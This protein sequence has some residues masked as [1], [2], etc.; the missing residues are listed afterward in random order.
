MMPINNYLGVLVVI[1][2][3]KD[4]LFQHNSEILTKAREI[5]DDLNEKLFAVVIGKQTDK[6]VEFCLEYG[7]DIVYNFE[8]NNQEW[9]GTDVYLNTISEVIEI[10]K[11]EIILL[12]ST[13]IGK[14]IASRL[15]VRFKTGVTA[16]CTNLTLEKDSR[17]LIQVRPAFGG[18]CLA[19]IE[20]PN[21]RPQI[22]TVKEKSFVAKKSFRQGT[23][24]NAEIHITNNQFKQQLLSLVNHQNVNGDC[25]SE[26]RVIVAG[27]LG[28]GKK[29]N[30]KLLHNLA[31]LLGG[32]VA[33]SRAIVDIGWISPEYQIGQTGKSIAPT[34]YIACGISG[35]IQHAIG[36]LQTELI[37]AINKD[38][39]APIFDYAHFGLVG[40]FEQVVT[41]L[42]Q[43]LKE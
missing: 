30:L 29:E 17:K 16:E 9:L 10:T 6:I 36:I 7:A 11:P 26:A 14:S 20:T 12:A 42:I 34:I 37:I 43:K 21:H 41:T 39:N 23:V 38:R 40:D 25:F 3:K 1:D 33:A 2:T 18:N 4:N 22:A 19:Y 27:G 35:A 32:S 31:D 13:L 15:G 8:S 28:I 24:V 5:S